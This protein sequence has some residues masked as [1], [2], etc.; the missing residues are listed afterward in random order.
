LE[1]WILSFNIYGNWAGRGE[2]PGL[3]ISGRENVRGNCPG[4]CPREYIQGEMSYSRCNRDLT[5]AEKRK[6]EI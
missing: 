2:C 4:R 3:S 6:R 5:A 1:K